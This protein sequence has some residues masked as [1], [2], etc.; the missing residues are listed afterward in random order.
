MKKYVFEEI[1][2]KIQKFLDEL[3]KK[4]DELNNINAKDFTN[5]KDYEDFFIGNAAPIQKPDLTK[6]TE[7][8][9]NIY[10]DKDN[11]TDSNKDA[12][13][14]Q[15]KETPK[16]DKDNKL[17]KPVIPSDTKTTKKTFIFENFNKTFDNF[18]KEQMSSLSKYINDNF[19]N[20]PD[21]FFSNHESFEWCD[22]TYS[23]YDFFYE[24]TKNKT[25][26]T[27]ILSNGT[28]TI[29]R[30]KEKL[31]NNFKYTIKFKIGLKSGG[32]FDVGIGTER[33]GDSCWLRTK[34]SICISNVGVMNLDINM[35]NSI[36]LKDNDI[37]DLEIS[38]EENKKYFKGFIN[39]KLVCVLDFDLNDIY[40]MAA[41]RNNAN[42]IEVLKYEVSPI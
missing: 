23:G 24:L 38:T 21:N 9:F 27:K 3:K 13:T 28:M 34:D 20:V 2:K 19:L 30:A 10:K 41:M 4:Y 36:K 26:G 22:I 25:K 8:C 1:E 29:L 42:F 37:I 31:E 33:C 40:I 7:I 35:D 14:E 5:L 17:D 18:V 16:S 11:N 6:L 15:K 12:T 32:D 39:E